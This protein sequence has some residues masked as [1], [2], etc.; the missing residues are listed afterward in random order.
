M[1]WSESESSWGPEEKA[2]RRRK[3]GILLSLANG[4]FSLEGVPEEDRDFFP[5]FDVMDLPPDVG[6]KAICAAVLFSLL[7]S[8]LSLLLLLKL[9]LLLFPN[10]REDAQKLVSVLSVGMA[11]FLLY[12]LVLLFG[13]AYAPRLQ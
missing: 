7:L 1:L 5:A 13:V 6:R 10:K 11:M 4:N 9:P 3:G 12:I 2:A 8:V